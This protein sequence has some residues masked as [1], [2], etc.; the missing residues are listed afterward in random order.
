MVFLGFVAFLAVCW[1]LGNAMQQAGQAVGQYNRQR[2]Q[3]WLDKHPGSVASARWAAAAATVVHGP[4]H[5]WRAFRHDWRKH[6]AAKRDAIRAKYSRDPEPASD[7]P[8]RDETDRLGEAQPAN[9]VDA[10]GRRLDE[11]DRR[12]YGLREDG[13]AGPIDE[14]GY[15]DT[16]SEQAAVLRHVAERTSEPT[17]RGRPRL[18]VVPDDPRSITDG[19]THDMPTMTE[20]TGINSLRQGGRQ[21]AGYGRGLAE[22]AAD[23]VGRARAY[24][25]MIRHLAESAPAVLDNDPGTAAAFQALLDPAERAVAAEEARA[26]AADALAA[27]AEQA[28][29]MLERHAAMEEAAKATSHASSNTSVYQ[30]D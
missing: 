3:A 15:P 10:F 23:A 26:A 13:Y 19:G 25:D 30:N 16:S 6:Y 14:D 8:S 27:G 20:I 1:A 5:A 22:D 9:R 24:R 2:K 4:R 29:A 17:D 18:W 28:L 21:T 12:H 11:R 7:A